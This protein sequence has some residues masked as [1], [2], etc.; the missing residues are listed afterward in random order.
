MFA[1]FLELFL[2]IYLCILVYLFVPIFAIDPELS[3]EEESRGDSTQDN[4]NVPT[5][6]RRG[7]KPHRPI[8][9]DDE[10]EEDSPWPF[11]KSK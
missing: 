10:E 2:K 8:Q 5:S 11:A 7:R 6:N 1:L 9:D 4:R 3:L